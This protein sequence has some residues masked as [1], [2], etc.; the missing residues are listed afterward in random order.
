M[1]SGEELPYALMKWIIAQREEREHHA[2][3]MVAQRAKEDG[4]LTKMLVDVYMMWNKLSKQEKIV[5]CN[6]LEWKKAG[7][8]YSGGQRGVIT[9]F[10]MKY[11]GGE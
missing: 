7:R 1:K 11:L 4:M 6:L 3:V 10:Y 8:N 2:K 9:T 5:L